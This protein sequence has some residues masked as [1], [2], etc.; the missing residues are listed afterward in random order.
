MRP[1]VLDYARVGLKSSMD[2]SCWGLMLQKVVRLLVGLSGGR[3][4]WFWRESGVG[5]WTGLE[6]GVG[7][8]S[9]GN[10]YG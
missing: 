5:T 4:G 3:G 10:S 2:S 6:V 7:L 8:N 1:L 9:R